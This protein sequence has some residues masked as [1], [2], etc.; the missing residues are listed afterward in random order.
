[1]C[2]LFAIIEL[3]FNF[4]S[5]TTRTHSQFYLLTSPGGS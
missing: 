5:L 4:W 2:V 3:S 1:M